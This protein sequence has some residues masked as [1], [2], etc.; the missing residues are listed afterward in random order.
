MS[1]LHFLKPIRNGDIFTIY[2]E[3]IA[4]GNSSIKIKVD[5]QVKCRISREEYYVTDSVFTFVIIDE[6][7][8]PINVRDVIREDV[9]D[10]IKKLL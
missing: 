1:D 10:D 9:L 8:K 4:I 2:A 5:V 7:K 3:V 6:N